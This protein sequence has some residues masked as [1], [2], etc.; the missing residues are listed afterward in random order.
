VSRILSA[1]RDAAD[2]AHGTDEYEGLVS[3]IEITEG[4]AAEMQKGAV[5]RALAMLVRMA[6]EH[7]DDHRG[8]AMR[9][10]CVA[11]R[12]EYD[13][14]RAQLGAWLDVRRSLPPI[15]TAVLGHRDGW[16]DVVARGADGGFFCASEDDKVMVSHWRPLPDPPECGAGMRDRGGAL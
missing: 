2:R 10:A 3:A 12:D 8:D 4:I 15:G 6:C 7:D 13:A 11:G 5:M 14:M 16:I 9:A 1:L